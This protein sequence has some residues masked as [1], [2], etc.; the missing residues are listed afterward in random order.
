MKVISVKT[1]ANKTVLQKTILELPELFNGE[2]MIEPEE[3]NE[4][5]DNDVLTPAQIE[6]AIKKGLIV[7]EAETLE[8]TQQGEQ[9]ENVIALDETAKNKAVIKLDGFTFLKMPNTK[10]VLKAIPKL[11]SREER[12][13]AIEEYGLKDCAALLLNF[14][15]STVFGGGAGYFE[16]YGISSA[17]GTKSVFIIANDITDT[18]VYERL[19]KESI[20]TFEYLCEEYRIKDSKGNEVK[21]LN[22][23]TDLEGN[24]I[25][26]N[27]KCFGVVNGETKETVFHVL[28]YDEKKERFS[29]NAKYFSN[30]VEYNQELK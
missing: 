28:K 6:L 5:I 29:L 30:L 14:A 19:T 1:P 21:E 2:T 20:P 13:E 27:Y 12:A 8:T 4:L 17:K 7:V 22:F 26:T 3:V 16:K 25:A 11:Q 23:P 18:N 10:K 15:E 9:K 24:T